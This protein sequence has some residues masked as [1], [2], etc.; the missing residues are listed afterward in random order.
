VLAFLTTWEGFSKSCP[1]CCCCY[2]FQTILLK[3][4]NPLQS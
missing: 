1:N 4:T 3:A 2:L